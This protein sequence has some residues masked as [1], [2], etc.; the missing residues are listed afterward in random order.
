ME[1]N[2]TGV[3]IIEGFYRVANRGF[4]GNFSKLTT[5][6]Y[7]NKTGV[8]V[9]YSRENGK[10]KSF[11]FP[12]EKF[13]PEQAVEYASKASQEDKMLTTN[14]L[15]AKTGD[16]K[17]EA[18]ASDDVMDR[19]GE[20]ISIDGWDL[21]NFKSNPVLLWLHNRA[22]G[23]DGRPI[24]RATSIGYREIDG[25]K[26]LV[27]TP[28]FDDTTQFNRETKAM[29]DKGLLNCFSVG[30]LP[31]EKIDNRFTKQ[32]LLEI[33]LV[34]VP[35]NAGAG[36]IQRAKSY[37]IDTSVASQFIE[38][39]SVI[40]YRE[41]PQA[42]ES[43]NWDGNGARQRIANWSK[44]D[45]N[46]N[47][48]KYQQGFTWYDGTK[49][50]L[51]GSYKLPHHDIEGSNLVTVW[52]GVVSAMGALMGAR[53]G[54]DIPES[55]RRKV[56]NHLAKH[57]EQFGKVAPDYKLIDTQEL[58]ELFDINEELVSNKAFVEFKKSQRKINELLNEVLSERRKQAPMTI[59]SNLIVSKSLE[60]IRDGITVSI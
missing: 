27:F 9:N 13:T 53:G 38:I 6:N 22:T 19:D 30:F 14:A 5:I 60:R 46:V 28:E 58:K 48:D 43:K 21:R 36:F 35:S 55:D 32:E 40:D 47:M 52:K 15:I 41:Y 34:P 3:D 20:I 8:K 2:K 1:V 24:G 39:K 54:V 12:I 4:N 16:K 59:D 49:P 25:K 42:P 26:R 11:L 45:G 57:Y 44:K 56:Y 18:I 29:V 31:K 23:H 7:D 10:I 37:G 33:S 17:Y 50:D 51:F